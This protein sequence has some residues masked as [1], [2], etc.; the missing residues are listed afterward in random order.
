MTT[1]IINLNS[2]SI[3]VW[4]IN[5]LIWYWPCIGLGRVRPRYE[6]GRNVILNNITLFIQHNYIQICIH[7]TTVIINLNSQSISVWHINFLIWYWPCI[8]LG[9][10]RPR[11][12]FGRNVILNNITLFNMYLTLRS[13]SYRGRT[14]WTPMKLY[15]KSTAIRPQ[16]F[17]DYFVKYWD[18]L[19]K[20]WHNY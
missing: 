12:E 15:S 10:V 13:N 5:F 14:E 2:Q 6:F 18:K 16:F 19:V 9:R 8:G 1:V 4:H 3:S 7:M 11:Y 17:H 20:F